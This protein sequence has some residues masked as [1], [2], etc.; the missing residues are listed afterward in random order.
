MR[1][2]VSNVPAEIAAVRGVLTDAQ[3]QQMP[4]VVRQAL[5]P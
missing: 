2:A 1:Q 3:W 5:T 4:E